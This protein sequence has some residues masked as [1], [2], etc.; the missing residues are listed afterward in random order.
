[1]NP[2]EMWERKQR[3]DPFGIERG[4]WCCGLARLEWI[5]KVEAGWV[6]KEIEEDLE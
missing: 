4:R 2:E 5:G 1:M 6:A 3:L